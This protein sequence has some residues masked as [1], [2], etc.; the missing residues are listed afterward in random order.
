M[1]PGALEV[2]VQQGEE[3]RWKINRAVSQKRRWQGAALS[4]STW[5]RG[6]GTSVADATG[7]CESRGGLKANRGESTE[8]GGA[9]VLRLLQQGLVSPH[10]HQTSPGK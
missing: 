3:T 7:P 8:P 5:T 1:S 6:G 4:R 2:A 9:F 10:R